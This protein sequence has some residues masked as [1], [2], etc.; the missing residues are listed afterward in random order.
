MTGGAVL[1][2]VEESTT[3]RNTVAHVLHEAAESEAATPV[4]HFVYPLSSRGRL[5]DEDEEARELLERIELWAEEDLGEDD[6]RVRVVTATVG[7]DEYLFSP[8]DYADVL[9]RYASQHDVE[10]V[11]LDPEYNPTGAT[12]LLPAL[13]SEIRGT[14]LSV[15]EAPVDRPTRRSRLVRRSGAGQFLLLFGL[16][17][18]FYLLLAW[19]LAPYDLVTGV[20]TGAV[21]STVLWHVSLTGPIQ[22][23]RLF[24]QMGRLC[25][26]VPF[27][28]WEIAKAN[29]G[30]AYVVLHPKLPIDPEV[31]EF[32]AAVWSEIPVATLAN[33]ITL[34]PGTLTID[35][36]SRHFTIHTLTA[37][38]REDLFDGSLERAVRFVF[39][40]RNAARMPTP[41]E[42]E[43]R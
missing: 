19:S 21:V 28:L 9:E 16:S 15:E 26:Y 30:I 41:S 5:G 39:Y 27:L 36:E 11:V 8:G 38:A 18:V 33:S 12:P 3:L 7:E 24:G 40:G 29:V 42:R 14:G 2:P 25:L 32:D 31:V 10:S 22:P 4:V 20:V 23:R 35:V 34:T 13:E 17:T 37:G 43:G 6:R 1:V